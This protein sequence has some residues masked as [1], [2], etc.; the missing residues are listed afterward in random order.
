MTTLSLGICPGTSCGYVWDVAHQSR[1]FAS[2][3]VW[4]GFSIIGSDAKRLISNASSSL[5][6][7]RSISASESGMVVDTNVFDLA[8]NGLPQIRKPRRTIL[9][10]W[11]I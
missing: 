3:L 7:L 5:M 11:V 1:P 9:L 2:Q 6:L 10:N 4:I 8:N